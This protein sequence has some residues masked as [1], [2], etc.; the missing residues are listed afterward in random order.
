MTQIVKLD[1]RQADW[2]S[3]PTPE[4]KQ[5]SGPVPQRIANLY[6]DPTQQFHVGFW[7][8]EAGSWKVT[9]TEHEYCQLL[10]GLVELEDHQGTIIRITAGEHFVIPA[11]FQGIWRTLQP[12]QKVYVI[13]EPA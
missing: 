11:G 7:G 12:C 8:S 6:S 9:Y 5:I 1:P 3:Y 10:E 4:E 2:Q 13:F